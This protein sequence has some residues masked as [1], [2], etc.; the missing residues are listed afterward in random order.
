MKTCR[1]CGCTNI[2]AC[3]DNDG[4]PCYWVEDD[5]CSACS[6][7]R[8]RYDHAHSLSVMVE[9]FKGM[10]KCHNLGT[11]VLT[12]AYCDELMAAL[13][14][15]TSD[16]VNCK[17]TRDIEAGEVITIDTLELRRMEHEQ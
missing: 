10:I 1:V 17:A 7:V 4:L 3:I 11:P 16:I 12:V 9:W 15:R 13:K 8:I 14:P 5:L 6:I 2:M